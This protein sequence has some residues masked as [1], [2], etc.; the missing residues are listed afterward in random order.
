MYHCV[1]SEFLDFCKAGKAKKGSYW[2][3][4]ATLEVQGR[5]KVM[6]QGQAVTSCDSGSGGSRNRMKAANKG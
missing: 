1:E 2:F 3:H 6:T 4:P 5:P